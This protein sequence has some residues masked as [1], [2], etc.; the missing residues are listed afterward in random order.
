M[1]CFTPWNL[2]NW[3]MLVTVSSIWILKPPI[4][5]PIE[6]FQEVV[7]YMGLYLKRY[8]LFNLLMIIKAKAVDEIS[9]GELYRGGK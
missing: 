7:D 9:L 5:Y 6:A 8:G 1:I 3:Q 2:G 4:R